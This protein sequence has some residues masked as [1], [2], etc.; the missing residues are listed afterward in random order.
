MEAEQSSVDRR[1]GYGEPG[2]AAESADF[3]PNQCNCD[4]DCP[5]YPHCI[6][7]LIH[8][9]HRCICDCWGDVL[10]AADRAEDRKYGLDEKVTICARAASLSRVGVV[11]ASIC[12]ANVF[13]P[14]LDFDKEMALSLKDVTLE[15]AIREAGL[16]AMA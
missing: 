16:I 8:D 11:L 14:A 4:N 1:I 13:V 12:T 5:G 7:I 6:C 9:E 15:D 10:L 2:R 3:D